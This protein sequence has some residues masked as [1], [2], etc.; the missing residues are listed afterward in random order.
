MILNQLIIKKR[1]ETDMSQ[2][3]LALELGI[4]NDYLCKVEK[5]EKI[6][7]KVRLSDISRIL[8]IDINLLEELWLIDKILFL[9]KE[10][11]RSDKIKELLINE[12]RKYI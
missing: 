10:E 12:Y 7:S 6:L 4:S 1:K 3:I 2:T 5:G 11:D 8:K 9:I